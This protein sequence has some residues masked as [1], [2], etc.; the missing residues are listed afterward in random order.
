MRGR[1][2]QT[3]TNFSNSIQMPLFEEEFIASE[4]GGWGHVRFGRSYSCTAG[5][6]Y[7][8][9]GAL[10]GICLAEARSLNARARV[11]HKA[12]REKAMT[13]FKAQWRPQSVANRHYFLKV[14]IISP[15][16]GDGI[17]RRGQYCVA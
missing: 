10:A 1:Q 17:L 15:Q 14:E 6:V 11:V 5:H 12:T 7:I 2:R 9:L 3:T 4:I 13:A 8:L 16:F